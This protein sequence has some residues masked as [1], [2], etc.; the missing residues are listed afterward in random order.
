MLQ[1]QHPRAITTPPARDNTWRQSTLVKVKDKTI[2]W[3]YLV[4]S[5]E[6]YKHH[7][8]AGQRIPSESQVISHRVSN[9]VGCNARIVLRV[10]G[11]EG[12]VVKFFEER[13]KHTMTPEECRAHL[14]INRIMTATHQGFVLNFIKEN[15]GPTKSFKLYKEI[16]G[17][18]TH[19]GATNVDFKNFKRELLA[20]IL[21]ADAQMV[22]D[23]FYKLQENSWT[24]YFQYELD[25][26][27]RLRRLFW[28]DPISRRNYGS[29][30]DVVSFDVTYSTNK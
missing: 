15:I 14:K 23:K 18:Y 13:H 1:Y 8:N 22:I 9:R 19:I 28:A 7:S 10:Y 3:R 24:F 11:V 2:L 25:D 17:G 20:Y 6:G 5:R 30:G 27:E 4:C 16:V 21:G 12:Y 26:K 29:F